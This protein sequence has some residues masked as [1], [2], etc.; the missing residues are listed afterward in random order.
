MVSFSEFD[1]STLVDL[2]L[3]CSSTGLRK[4]FAKAGLIASWQPTL[5]VLSGVIVTTAFER[6]AA[7]APTSCV[8]CSTWWFSSPGSGSARRLDG[9]PHAGPLRQEACP[10]A[11]R[12]A[13]QVANPGPAEAR[14]AER[15]PGPARN[16]QCRV[17]RKPEMARAGRD[18]RGGN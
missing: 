14:G 4:P 9:P 2:Q 12:G 1:P 8:G 10:G 3:M 11:L 13:G 16:A 7:G 5:P 18:L 17:C 6:S 15:V